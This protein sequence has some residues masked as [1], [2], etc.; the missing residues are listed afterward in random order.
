MDNQYNQYIVV[1][2]AGIFTVV[3]VSI[4]KAAERVQKKHHKK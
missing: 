2:I 1:L 3:V 4:L